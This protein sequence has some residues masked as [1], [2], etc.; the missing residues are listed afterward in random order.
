MKKHVTTATILLLA[1]TACTPQGNQNST[2]PEPTSPSAETTTND[3]GLPK[4]TGEIVDD[5][6]PATGMVAQKPTAAWAAIT[7]NERTFWTKQAE[8]AGYAF[9][10]WGQEV[11]WL[12]GAHLIDPERRKW[13]ETKTEE[14]ATG[15][16]PVVRARLTGKDP[17]LVRQWVNNEG[18]LAEIKIDY[19]P[20][21]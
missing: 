7:E 18:E 21:P 15:G 1:L 19:T 4:S 5:G 11:I 8:G 12:D 3:L 14:F 2:A 13:L 16:G 17:Y 10:I 6:H 20:E 9:L